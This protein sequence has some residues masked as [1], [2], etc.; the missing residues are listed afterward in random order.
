MRIL[1]LYVSIVSVIGLSS[2]KRCYEC[3]CYLNGQ[4]YDE[5]ECEKG[6]D[7]SDAG[8]AANNHEVVLEKE[9]GYDECVC[10]VN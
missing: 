6:I 10:L 1:L 4:E 3:K 5:D 8:A 2:C 9:K 7:N